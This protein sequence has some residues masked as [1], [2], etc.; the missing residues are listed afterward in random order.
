MTI[1]TLEEYRNASKKEIRECFKEVTVKG[2]VDEY[3]RW[4]STNGMVTEIPVTLKTG[5]S[6]S[7][8][9]HPSSACKVGVCQYQLYL[10]CTGEIEKKSSIEPQ[11]QWTFDIG[12]LIH[13]ALQAHLHNMYGD[14]FNDE[15]PLKK[16]EL[17]IKGTTDGMFTFPSTR[18]V[19]EIK[20]IKE[21]GNYGFSRVQAK[22]L[23]DNL[24][25]AHIY[26]FCADV[27]FA[28]LYYVCKNTGE[29][30]EHAVA[31]DEKIWEDILETIQPV[32]D[33][34]KSKELQFDPKP[35][36]ACYRCDFLHGCEHGRRYMKN[37]SSAKTKKSQRK[38]SR[39]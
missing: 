26:M 38:I 25:Q 39:F 36:G 21:G 16:P 9:I 17:L 4:C 3:L 22:P 5:T 6:R 35:G 1:M 27:P 29:S 33:S 19:L 8:G 14:Q 11:L 7:L 23:E 37:A 32:V 18:F 20:S 15:I 31:F 2:E 34:V 13:F 10:E 30:K 12:T 24:R 28:L